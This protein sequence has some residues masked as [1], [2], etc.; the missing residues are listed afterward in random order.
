MNEFTILHCYW[1]IPNKNVSYCIALNTM[2]PKAMKLTVSTKSRQKVYFTIT[3]K[4]LHQF[5]S[6]L[7]CSYINHCWTVLSY[8]L[9][10]TCVHTLS[11]NVMSD[12]IMTE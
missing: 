5:P 1:D 3:L 2:M 9:H 12:K 7:A 6:N 10:L 11:C 4:M 8:L